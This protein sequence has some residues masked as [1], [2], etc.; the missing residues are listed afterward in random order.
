MQGSPKAGPKTDSLG[1]PRA[2]SSKAGGL[3]FTR[4]VPGGHKEKGPKAGGGSQKGPRG[5]GP[6]GA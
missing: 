2:C 5:E 6:S 4:G 1:V 3:G